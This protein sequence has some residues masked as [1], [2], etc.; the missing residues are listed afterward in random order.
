MYLS[1]FECSWLVGWIIYFPLCTWVDGFMFQ[2]QCCFPICNS[3][4]PSP[5]H[6]SPLPC[7]LCSCS[8]IPSRQKT[9]T[10][11]CWPTFPW[12]CLT[13]LY[14][15]GYPFVHLQPFLVRFSSAPHFLHMNQYWIRKLWSPS[16]LFLH[17]I[18]SSW[19]TASHK[20]V[21]GLSW[22]S[23]A[24][25]IHSVVKFVAMH[26]FLVDDLTSS[27]SLLLLSLHN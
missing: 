1:D 18:I 10:W 13:L 8:V 4:P 19:N 12:L 5:S 15:G 14:A 23:P 26:C 20:D 16:V 9:L 2:L 17:Q 7:V 22:N 21:L 24:L 3:P 11:L 6:L 25:I 27:K